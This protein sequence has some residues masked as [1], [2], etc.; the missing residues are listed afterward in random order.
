MRALLKSIDDLLRGNLTRREDLVAGR[1][2]VPVR[3]LLLAGLVMGALYGVFMGLYA[4]LRTGNPSFAQLVATMV[5]VP[6]LFLLTLAVTCPSLYVVS[7]LFDSRLRHKET[8]RLLLA[9]TG[10]NLALLASLGPVTGFFTLS[11]ES[12]PFMVVLNVV[13]FAV[14]G[15]AGLAFLRRALLAVFDIFPREEELEPVEEAH[16]AALP[17]ADAGPARTR[18]RSA[19]RS[20]RIFT[21][22]IIIYGVVGA[23]MGWILRPFIGSPELEF[24]LFRVRE[25][26][27]FQAVLKATGMLFR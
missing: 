27:F 25:S 14:A 20:L 2:E 6:A 18:Q 26:N 10:V 19:P 12:Y 11:T 23:Q 7:A 24:A 5:K 15:F 1:V 3:T 17:A 9:A 22:W 21:L 4:V 16:G 8:L 13:F